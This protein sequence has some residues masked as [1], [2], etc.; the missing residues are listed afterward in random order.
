[1]SLNTH[2]LVIG[3]SQY[4]HIRP[5]P[6]VAYATDLAGI[7]RDPSACGYD[8]ANVALLQE[9]EATRARILDQLDHL[10]QRAS[11]DST[12]L[13]YFSGHGGRPAGDSGDS[14]LV[15]IDGEWGSPEQLEATAI[16]SQLLGQKLAAIRAERLTVILDC[17]HAAG[18]A[19]ARDVKPPDWIPELA[20]RALG[21]L[22]TGR[23]RVVMAAA[24]DDGSAYVMSGSRHGLFTEHLI[25]GLRGAA[26]TADGMVRVLDLYHHVRRNVVARYPAQRPVLKA[27]LEDNYPIA[28]APSTRPALTA[29]A[30]PASFAYDVLLVYSPDERDSAWARSFL[31]LLED[32][33]VRV[34]TEELDTELGGHRILEIERLVSTSRFTLPV[35]TPRFST[36]RFQELQT[37]MAQHLGIEDGRARL[38]PIVREPCDARLGLRMLVPLDMTR[39]ENVLPSVERLVRTLR[40]HATA[41][42][43]ADS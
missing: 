7:L 31:R 24:R 19:Q 27:E 33:G 22:A 5:L 11:A 28:L 43:L 6:P 15:P 37:V 12:A 1:M 34:C 13:V 10:G 2:A 36:G 40:K 38:I 25:A 3:V 39:D 26:A 18:L 20:D 35:L 41:H 4:Q 17:C 42:G 23:G 32:R 8:P 14:Y 29:A 9:A 21:R 30:P 16:S